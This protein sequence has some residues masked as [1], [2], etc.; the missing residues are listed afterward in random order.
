MGV[1][2]SVTLLTCVFILFFLFFVFWRQVVVFL[3]QKHFRPKYEQKDEPKRRHWNLHHVLKFSPYAVRLQ[4]HS[5]VPSTY[6]KWQA[7]P[8]IFGA[9]ESHSFPPF[10]SVASSHSTSW[11]SW[12]NEA[13]SVI[14]HDETFN[15]TEHNTVLINSP[16]TRTSWSSLVGWCG[17][18]T[19]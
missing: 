4:C 10:F 12:Q 3:W 11:F 5:G 7:I 2:G 8:F 19:T 6:G 17:E 1:C 14:F 9:C 18:P 16:S 13:F 15:I